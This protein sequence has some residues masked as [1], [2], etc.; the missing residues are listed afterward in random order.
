MDRGATVAP[1]TDPVLVRLSP[2]AGLFGNGVGEHAR[3]PAAPAAGH[4]PAHPRQETDP[5][6]FQGSNRPNHNSWFQ[7]N[8]AQLHSSYWCRVHSGYMSQARRDRWLSCSSGRAWR[9]PACRH[10]KLASRS[11]PTC[12]RGAAVHRA[13][14]PTGTP[15]KFRCQ[16][17]MCTVSSRPLRMGSRTASGP[18]PCTG[19]CQSP[20]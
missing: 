2:T 4:I 7:P 9:L 20:A 6:G 1:R 10:C 5:A 17:R 11:R 3:R 12:L 15:R 18:V 14:S 16:N 13:V 19:A 8:R